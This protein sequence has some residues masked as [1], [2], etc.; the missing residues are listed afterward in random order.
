MTAP[1]DDAVLSI[2]AAHGVAARHVRPLPSGVAN[3]AYL[4]G[5]DLVLRVARSP[6]F[7]A[8]LRTEA[9]VVPLARAAGVRTAEVVAAGTDP[10]PHLVQMRLPGA[11]M[12]ARPAAAAYP[13]VGR[14]LARLH[15]VREVPAEVPADDGAPDPVALLGGLCLDGWI[16]NGAAA[17]LAECFARLDADVPADPPRVLIHGDIAPQ[18]LLVSADGDLTG[19]VDWGDAMVADAATDF[20]KVRLEYVPA[21]LAGYRAGGA[22]DG[23]WEARVLRLHLLWALGRLRDAEPRPGR[24]HWTVSP[25]GRLLWL[26]HFLATGPSPLWRRYLAPGFYPFWK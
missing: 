6:A 24:R 4:L 26:L 18:N 3:R 5:D 9:V 19:I 14:Q 10:V 13:D 2:A 21:V 22:P 15:R 8:D 1:V 12:V 16:D 11:D 7:A 23:P 20:A 17:W 25:A